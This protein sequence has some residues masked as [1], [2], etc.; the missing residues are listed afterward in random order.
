VNIRILEDFDRGSGGERDREGEGGMDETV[1]D[2]NFSIS[3]AF[4]SWI[5]C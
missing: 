4:I 5:T 3:F 1:G 2:E